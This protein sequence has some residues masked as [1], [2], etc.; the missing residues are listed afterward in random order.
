MTS[1]HY[2]CDLPQ[3]LRSYLMRHRDR[4]P[5][6]INSRHFK[7]QPEHGYGIEDADSKPE[8]YS[9]TFQMRLC[10]L[11]KPEPLE[12][13]V[14]RHHYTYEITYSMLDHIVDARILEAKN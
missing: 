2:V 13:K 4:L 1:L 12:D 3:M 7:I 10:F 8:D 11:H 5:E 14:V 9:E 6:S